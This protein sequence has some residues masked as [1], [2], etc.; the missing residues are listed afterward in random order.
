MPIIRRTDDSRRRTDD[1]SPSRGYHPLFLPCERDLRDPRA[2][3]DG[4]TCSIARSLHAPRGWIRP[5]E[6]LARA[7]GRSTHQRK[8][9]TL[10]LKSSRSNRDLRDRRR[11]DS[12]DWKKLLRRLTERVGQAIQRR[13]RNALPTLL[14]VEQRSATNARS[15]R[16]LLLS[17]PCVRPHLSESR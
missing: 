10:G 15:S 3:Y 6:P 4:G 12:R 14:D 2:R 1:V 9:G 16:Q 13:Q 17:E 5:N 11:P 8:N 7:F